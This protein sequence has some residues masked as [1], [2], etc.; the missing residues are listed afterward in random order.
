[1]FILFFLLLVIFLLCLRMRHLQ[2]MIAR[3]DEDVLDIDVSELQKNNVNILAIV[4]PNEK[5]E[6][7]P[8]DWVD[9]YYSNTTQQARQRSGYNNPYTSDEWPF[10]MYS[11]MYKYPGFF[12]SGYSWAFKPRIIFSYP[13]GR[14]F[15]NNGI[16]Y[17]LS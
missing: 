7:S 6:I 15:K 4:I 13:T 9:A 10:N 3:R 11:S 2:D 5:F 14:W 1:M 8:S 16:Y 17:Y 12:V